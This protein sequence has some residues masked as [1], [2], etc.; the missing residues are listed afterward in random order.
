MREEQITSYAKSKS[1]HRASKDMVDFH[2]ALLV[3]VVSS[4][5][6][7]SS[8]TGG[9]SSHFRAFEQKQMGKQKANPRFLQDKDTLSG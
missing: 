9:L 6:G 2:N 7:I 8:K 4:T 3:V 1:K 5:A